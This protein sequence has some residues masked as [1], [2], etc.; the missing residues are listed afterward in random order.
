MTLRQIIFVLPRHRNKDSF[1]K[2]KFK[3][4]LLGDGSFLFPCFLWSEND[5]VFFLN[6][7]TLYAIILIAKCCYFDVK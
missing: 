5:D 2:R 1:F 7:C 3:C 6:I 4:I